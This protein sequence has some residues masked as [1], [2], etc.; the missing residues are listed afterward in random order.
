MNNSSLLPHLLV[1]SSIIADSARLL[2]PWRRFETVVYW[3]GH[4]SDT[5]TVV[6]SVIR[7]RQRNT[8]GSFVVDRSANADVAEWLC[9]HKL[10]LVAQLHTHPSEFVGHSCGDDLGAPFAFHGF[11]SLVIPHHGRRGIL[12]L[13][14]CGVYVFTETFVEIPPPEASQFIKVVPHA[15]DLKS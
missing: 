11:Y 3:A 5:M 7:P 14:Q 10:T 15:I 6:T 8:F 13:T 2:R 9:E 4:A 12:P 1:S